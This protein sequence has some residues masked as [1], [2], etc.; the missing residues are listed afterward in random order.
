MPVIYYLQLCYKW[1]FFVCFLCSHTTRKISADEYT[2]LWMCWWQWT[3]YRKKRRKLNGLDCPP[4]LHRNASTWR[5]SKGQNLFDICKIIWKFA[6]SLP[7]IRKKDNRFYCF[8][9]SV[10]TMGDRLT[11][12]LHVWSLAC[13]PLE[14]GA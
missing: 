6:N 12:P 3:L 2:T 5:Y 13:F 7:L 9:I 14:T 4:I 11:L 8:Y 1:K 10:K